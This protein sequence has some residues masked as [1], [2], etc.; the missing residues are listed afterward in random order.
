MADGIRRLTFSTTELF[1]NFGLKS[2]EKPGVDHSQPSRRT[3]SDPGEGHKSPEYSPNQSIQNDLDNLVSESEK[4]NDVS[5][6]SI[7]STTNESNSS[8]LRLSRGHWKD[9][10]KFNHCHRCA[11]PFGFAERKFN[12]RRF[13]FSKLTLVVQ[14]L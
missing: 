2:S 4:S 8:F 6:S 5:P 14:E 13:G 12:C 11:K 3:L 1:K 10:S 9:T 7:S